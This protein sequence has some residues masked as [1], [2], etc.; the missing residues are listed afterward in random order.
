[1]PSQDSFEDNR[2]WRRKLPDRNLPPGSPSEEI[3]SVC[4]PGPRNP[5]VGTRPHTRLESCAV[6]FLGVR[7]S[8][9]RP[10]KLTEAW[11]QRSWVLVWLLLGGPFFFRSS[12]DDLMLMSIEESCGSP[13]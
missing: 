1:M 4:C 13:S 7:A 8:A 5:T 9:R 11:V 3:G 6:A 2:H 12:P 10:S